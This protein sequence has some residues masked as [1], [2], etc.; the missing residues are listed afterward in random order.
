MILRNSIITVENILKDNNLKI[1]IIKFSERTRSSQE[2]ANAIGCSIAQIGKS[3]IFKGKKSGKPICVIASGKNR[4]NEKKLEILIG[5]QI[6]RADAEY[7]K[8]HT[9][10]IIGGVA[11]VG[12]K[13][14]KGPFIDSDLIEYK[15]EIYIS[16]G[17]IYAVFKISFIDLIKITNGI[18]IK[19]K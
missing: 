11:P 6:E 4:V 16:A 13:F 9:G 17:D 10:F 7:V 3:L 2:A 18:V 15:D 19:V 5:E 12:Y 14:E 1:N 8:T